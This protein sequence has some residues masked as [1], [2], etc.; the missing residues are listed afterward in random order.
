[1][2]V[3]VVQFGV[4]TKDMFSVLSSIHKS[5]VYVKSA[6]LTPSG[7]SN[8]VLMWWGLANCRYEQKQQ[9]TCQLEFLSW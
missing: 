3:Y 6:M 2:E 5:N 7:L 4:P 8:I 9:T 1:M